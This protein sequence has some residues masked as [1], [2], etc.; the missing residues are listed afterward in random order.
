MHGLTELV[1]V[2]IK[3]LSKHGIGK[4]IYFVHVKYSFIRHCMQIV[5][6]ELNFF[7]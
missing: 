2:L 7:L 4:T 5:L 3:L 6:F 1:R